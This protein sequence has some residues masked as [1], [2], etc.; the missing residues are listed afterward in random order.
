MILLTGASG[1]LGRLITASLAETSGTRLIIGS[2][3]PDE[4]DAAGVP[5]RRIDFD[6]PETLATGF[7][8]VDVLVMVSAGYAEDDVVMARYDAAIAAARAAGVRH[9]VYTSFTGAGAHMTVSMTH[10][11][12]ERLLESSGMDYTLLRNGLYAEV[13]APLAAQAC[14]TG[15]LDVPLGTGR[16]ALVSRQDLA[17]AAAR[18]AAEADADAAGPHRGRTYE[19]AGTESFGG[20]ELAEGLSARLGRPVAYRSG[21]LGELR[22]PLAASGLRPF[23]VGHTI[24]MFGN[25]AAGFL[26]GTDTELPALLTH[27]PRHALD[28]IAAEVA[29]MTAG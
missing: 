15:V 18:V 4:V 20:A 8:G 19:L 14:L 1:A 9:V 16:I 6:E 11:Y 10:R 24:S 28:V 7:A 23:E 3:R 22:E 26:A 5:V 17:E 21:G 29:A 12:A 25:I 27:P 2:R 13:V